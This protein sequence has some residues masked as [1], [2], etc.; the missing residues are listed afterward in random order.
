M[1]KLIWII[2]MGMIL[3]PFYVSAGEIE[4]L[5]AELVK[6]EADF[7]SIEEAKVLM[8]RG[9]A[10]ANPVYL[11]LIA[12]QNDIA[13]KA[14]GIRSRIQKLQAEVPKPTPPKPDKE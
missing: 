10:A 14:Q 2:A 12:Q 1:K 7:N 8:I 5:Q 9:F 11:G 3:I 6:M 13:T 4:D